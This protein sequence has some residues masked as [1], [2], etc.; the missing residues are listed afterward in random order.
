MKRAKKL[1][2]EGEAEFWNKQHYARIR[3]PE[4]PGGAAYNR[5][6]YVPDWV[7]VSGWLFQTGS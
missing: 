2:S 5:Q 6:K 4:S 7:S 1:V 3:F